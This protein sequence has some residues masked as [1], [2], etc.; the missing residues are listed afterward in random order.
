[1]LGIINIIVAEMFEY[2]ELSDIARDAKFVVMGN[3]YCI[4]FLSLIK[5]TEYL[6]WNAH[7][8]VSDDHSYSIPW[9]IKYENTSI[10]E[11]EVEIPPLAIYCVKDSGMNMHFS[12]DSY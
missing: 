3:F 11:E 7:V 6:Y 2:L 4:I 1:M 9:C 8:I 10:V 5:T 12:T